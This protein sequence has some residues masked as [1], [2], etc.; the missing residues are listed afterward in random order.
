MKRNL[1]KNSWINRIEN[2]HCR[3]LLQCLFCFL[4]DWETE[5]S[6]RKRSTEIIQKII[7]NGSK[8]LTVKELALKYEI[9]QKTLRNDVKE[10]NQFLR[11]IP[12]SEISI[13][14]KG[15]LTKASDFDDAVVEKYLYE[16]DAY[17]YKLSTQ[18]RQIYIM[19]ILTTSH[20]HLTMQMFA[21]EL[22]VSRI[23]IVNDIDNIKEK[24]HEYG[25]ELAMDPGKGMFLQCSEQI[26]I[27]ILTSL[28]RKIA[29]NIRNDGF[30]QRMILNRM[31]IQYSFSNI[32]LYMQ[33]YMQ[34]SNLVFVED[35]FYDIV[36]YLFVVFNFGKKEGKL[37]NSKSS[38]NGIDHM[39]L[40][41]G[42]MLNLNVTQNMLEDFRKYIN[43]HNLYSFVKTVDEIELYKVIM[44]FVEAIDIEV[45]IGL[46]N[47]S[48]LLD[49]LLMHIKNM[50]DWGNYE[51]EL[52]MEYNSSINYEW[53]VNLVEKNSYILERFLGYELSDNMKKSIVIHICVAM[54]RNRR[55][56]QRLSVVIVCPGSMA[57]GKY[58]EAQIRN[59]FDFKVVGVLSA[60]EVIPLLEKRNEKIDFIISTVSIKTEKYQVIKVHPFLK[61]DDM[62]MIQ[63]MTFQ[64]Q[65]LE[66][67]PEK[68]KI[69][70]L[71]NM[72]QDFIEDKILADLLC[73]KLIE[74]FEEYQKEGFDY[75][76]NEMSELLKKEYIQ[77]QEN[78]ILWKEAM[79][80]AAKPLELSGDIEPQYIKKA[81]EHVEEF[82]DY[83]V[84]S[85][86]VAL[87]HA[88]RD[89]GVH[90]DCLSLLVSKRGIQFTETE[91][92]VYL[93]FCFAS[94]GKNEYL[95]LL[96]TIV[97]IGKEEGK[98]E[99]IVC[100]NNIEEIYKE[101]L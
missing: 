41:A 100:L 48:K 71:K 64:K 19:M 10:I 18:E 36:L 13:T 51:V 57:T 45:N 27:E 11:T 17:M 32:F 82:G 80:Q 63:K 37:V 76:K 101:L 25:A 21:E 4:L 28:Y 30:F 60:N 83:I 88:N 77:I 2:K 86:G 62:N 6:M 3:I 99:K 89:C 79:H 97:Q 61:M 40:Y 87:A 29:I 94:T 81:I 70:M 73:K 66:H 31:N 90:K 1:D 39:I 38:L 26:R 8:I 53:L 78:E 44:H 47:D 68:Q 84:V 69:T 67:S 15:E 93:L 16:M 91:D 42:Y 34:V 59:Y 12:M 55:Y 96:K 74:V 95:E 35:V 58:L 75:R 43:D 50:R 52:P 7:K 46:G 9:S 92:R 56:M 85:K 24:F 14:E 20:R 5:E 54:I 98:V 72:I 33:E 22:Y 65:K 23:T 49:S